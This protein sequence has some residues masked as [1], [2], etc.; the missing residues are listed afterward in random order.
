LNATC[1]NHPGEPAVGNCSRCGTFLCTAEWTVVDGAGYCPA[2]AARDDVDYLEAFRKKYWGKRDSWAWTIGLGAPAQLLGGLFTLVT[3]PPEGYLAGVLLVLSGVNSAFFFFGKP[4][5]RLGLVL[6][7]VAW[8]ASYA[9]LI[10]PVALVSGFV[11]ALLVVSIL[12][13]TRTKLFF[14][15]D[16]PRQALA[17]CWDQLA[18]NALAG[19]SLALA[20]G[21]L[22]VPGFGLLAIF[23]GL[24]ALTRV[25]RK[26]RPP[27]GKAG[28]AIGGIILGVLGS[29]LTG[30][31]VWS[32]Y[33]NMTR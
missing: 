20:V 32:A 24:V 26:S 14:K 1:P 21:G 23:T 16:V 15:L 19:T 27:I 13:T 22:L 12:T 30:F 31:V 29:G 6:L 25:N 4:L 7:T 5:S 17:K 2:C 28:Q 33:W 9:F 11:G 18:N 10:G 8:T 3:G